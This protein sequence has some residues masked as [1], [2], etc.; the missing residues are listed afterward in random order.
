MFFCFFKL[1]A[2]VGNVLIGNVLFV[3]QCINRSVGFSPIASAVLPSKVKES[4]Q[5][6]AAD[7]T[8][9]AHSSCGVYVCTLCFGIL[10]IL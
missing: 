7:S 4:V 10:N 1:F 3:L 5:T 9:K 8:T 2:V 6:M